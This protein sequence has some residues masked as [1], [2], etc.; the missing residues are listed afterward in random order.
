AITAVAPS[1][2]AAGT[3]WVGTSNGLV[4]VTTD[5]GTTWKKVLET[6]APVQMVEASPSAAGA[7]AV[8]ATGSGGELW[9]TS[10]AGQHWSN[11]GA[12]L[13]PNLHAVAEDPIEPGLWFAGGDHGFYVRL[14]ADAAW[15]PLQLNLPASSVRGVV[16]VHDDVAVATYGRGMWVLDDISPLRHAAAAETSASAG[17]AYLYTPAEVIRVHNDN[18]Q[19]MPLEPEVPAAPNPRGPAVFDYYLPP[20]TAGPV[21]LSIYDG[22]GKLVRSFSSAPQPAPNELFTVPG[23]WFAPPPQL[24]DQAGLNRFAWDLRM[25]DPEVINQRGFV[26]FEVGDDAVPGRAPRQE[27]EGY[28]IAPGSYNARLMVGATVLHQPFK[29]VLD[30]RVKLS[31][32]TI[33]R[34]VALEAKVAAALAISAEGFQRAASQPQLQRP[35]ATANRALANYFSAISS[36]DGDPNPEIR[37]LYPGLCQPLAAAVKTWNASRAAK[38]LAAPDCSSIAAMAAGAHPN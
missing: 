22:Q 30:P 4:Q 11:A 17:R 25:P 20:A 19:D 24:P 9:S 15:Q 34:Q 8:V 10:D 38:P 2:V 21:T 35:F 27:P 29:I 36:G 23:Y 14:G 5:G 16:V 26:S 7:A 31:P 18:D 1:P 32:A 33:V 6:G 13:P 3:I 37:G 28:I 12:G